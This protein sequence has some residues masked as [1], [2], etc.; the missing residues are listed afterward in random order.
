[1]DSLGCGGLLQDFK[2]PLL[3]A[4]L[5]EFYLRL[6]KLYVLEKTRCYL[7]ILRGSTEERK[8]NRFADLCTLSVHLNLK[9][10][11]I[12][13]LIIKIIVQW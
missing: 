1:M 11:R 2:H 13:I 12:A 8:Y 3:S 9:H 4:I 6:I 10:M 7:V 5:L